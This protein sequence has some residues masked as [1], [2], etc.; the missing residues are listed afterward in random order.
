MGNLDYEQFEKDWKK[1]H[2]A[3]LPRRMSVSSKATIFWISFWL[4]VSVGAAIFSAVHTIPAAAMTLDDTIPQRQLFAITA[5]VIVEF[6]IFGA[7]AKRHE[8][9]WL[10]YLLFC[11]LAVALIG[12][13]SSSFN[14]VNANG[15]NALNQV[16][17][18]LLS[19][20]APVTA[21][22][23]GEVLHM[24]LTALA[25]RQKD[26][27]EDFQRQWKEVDAKINSAFTKLEKEA[28]NEVE[29]SVNLRK[30]TSIDRPSPKMKK[31]IEWLELHPEHLETESRELANLIG[32]SHT[33]AND[34]RKHVKF[35]GNGHS[36]N[37]HSEL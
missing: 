21:L 20:I 19:I 27:N 31:A 1:R 6:V 34:A 28:K 33:L 35:S 32:V 29:S 37:G 14:A 30:F 12:N 5:F 11:S 24:Q 25:Q 13:V 2:K 9:N 8:I 3:S 7:S 4:T 17:G 22:A 18:V 26:S 16:A 10:K 15:G 23:A 36:E